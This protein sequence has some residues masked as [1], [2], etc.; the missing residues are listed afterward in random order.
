MFGR[1]VWSLYTACITAFPACFETCH[2]LSTSPTLHSRI[3]HNGGKR[4]HTGIAEWS[5][6]WY[7]LRH[8][9]RSLLKCLSIPSSESLT[10]SLRALHAC[11]DL[12]T[13][14]LHN[15]FHPPSRGVQHGFAIDQTRSHSE[16][17]CL[18]LDMVRHPPH[19]FDVC[20]RLWRVRSD[21]YANIKPLSDDSL[22]V[23]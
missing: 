21:V 7:S 12:A 13:K 17:H 22:T 2:F 9:S 18:F 11:F 19:L 6:L 16:W 3:L 8:R 20:V 14:P 10:G 15:L 23:S 4:W 1:R 5:R